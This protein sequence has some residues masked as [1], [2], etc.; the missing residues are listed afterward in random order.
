MKIELQAKVQQPYLGG[1]QTLVVHYE[2]SNN[3]D[4]QVKMRE[5]GRTDDIGSQTG[6]GISR[7]DIP[8]LI[9]A[10]QA[11]LLAHPIEE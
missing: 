3:D 2:P 5:Q 8:V 6:F 10:L 9:T 1:L 11:V 7:T 4:V